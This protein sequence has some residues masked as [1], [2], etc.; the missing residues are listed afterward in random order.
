MSTSKFMV[1]LRSCPLQKQYYMI[2]VSSKERPLMYRGMFAY[3]SL[4]ETFQVHGFKVEKLIGAG[5]Y[6]FP[7]KLSSI[8]SSLSS[9]A[10]CKPPEST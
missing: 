2:K 1:M 7:K 5:Y 8:L 4:K 6:P 9:E 10:T 3:R